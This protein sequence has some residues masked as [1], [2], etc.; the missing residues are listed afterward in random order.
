MTDATLFTYWYI[1]LGVT[2]VIVVIAAVLLHLVWQ[3][4]QRI[5]TL[6]VAA[7]GL[8]K[9]IKENTA[10]VWALEDTNKTAL[11][12]LSE[13]N[14]IRDHGAAVAHALHKAGAK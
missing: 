7:L 2:A 11:N 10:I 13:A 14:S 9:Q 3:A 8:V 12:I 6:A 4:A 1:G 5:L